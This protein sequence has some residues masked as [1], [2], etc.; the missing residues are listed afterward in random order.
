MVWVV[1]DWG[2]GC[3]VVGSMRIGRVY[4]DRIWDEK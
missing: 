3:G 4:L 2:L 1:R